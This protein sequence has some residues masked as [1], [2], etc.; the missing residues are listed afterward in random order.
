LDR[1]MTVDEHKKRL[2]ALPLTPA[3]LDPLRVYRQS[4]LLRILL[5]DVLQLAD[6][7]ALVTE[8]STLAEACLTTVHQL[9][10]NELNLTIIA[11]GKFGGSEIGYGAD[12]DV[13]F[14]GDDIRAAQNLTVTMAQP[15]A[16]GNIGTLD[17]RLRPD[18]EKGNLACSLATYE[19]YY[20]TRAQVWE[21]QALTKA[22][23]VAGP[24]QEQFTVLAQRLWRT[25]AQRD[26]LFSQI[27]GM[28]RR[29]RQERGTAADLLDFKTGTGG[30]IEAEFLIQ[31]LQ[32]KAGIWNPSTLGAL[33]ALSAEGLLSKDEAGTLKIHYQ[34]LR[35]I[36][37]VLRRWENKS[38]STLPPDEL[39]QQRLACRMGAKSLDEFG[40]TYR[41]AREAIHTIASQYLG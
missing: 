4:Q 27:A 10:G 28:L 32:W 7:E 5:R 29:I 20:A 13:L 40:K 14:V 16:E 9:Y 26:D 3:S 37:S 31:A 25:T 34:F 23:P 22:R 36:E 2:Q 24:E 17:A 19:A 41:E 35:Q 6:L 38:V 21:A 18:G 33:S 8:H 11:M 15:T 12:M 1:Q 30:I 39:E